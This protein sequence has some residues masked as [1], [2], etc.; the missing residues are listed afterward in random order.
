MGADILMIRL[1]NLWSIKRAFTKAVIK[2]MFIKTYNLD[3]RQYFEHI[4]VKFFVYYFP[5]NKY[6]KGLTRSLCG[7]EFLARRPA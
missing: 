4:K 7:H 1:L 6:V 5:F 3:L 2:L